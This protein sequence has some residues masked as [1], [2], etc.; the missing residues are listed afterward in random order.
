MNKKA[1]SP[2]I[3]T[4]ILVVFALVVGTITMNWGK[5]YVNNID[6]EKPK[7]SIVISMEDINTPLKGLQID[8]ITGK[9]TLEEY[10]AKEKEII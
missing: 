5:S 7:T 2:L 10:L 1:V 8:Y 4:I 6:E 9:I 3:A